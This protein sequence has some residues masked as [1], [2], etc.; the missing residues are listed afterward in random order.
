M[1]KASGSIEADPR[2]LDSMMSEQDL[3]ERTV[4]Q[5]TGIGGEGL[6]RKA[7]LRLFITGKVIG[8]RNFIS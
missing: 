6:D 1:S 5:S 7:K 2:A 3:F 8:Y 4:R